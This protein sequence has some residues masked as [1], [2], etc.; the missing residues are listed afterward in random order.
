MDVKYRPCKTILEQAE[1]RGMATGLVATSTIT[2]ATPA[3]FSSHVQARGMEPEIAAQ[4]ISGGIDVLLGGG[5]ASFLPQNKGGNRN[6]KRNL[7]KEAASNGYAVVTSPLFLGSVAQTPLLGLFA[8]G[9]MAYEVDRDPQDEPS[10][11]DMTTTAIS[12]LSKDEDGFFLVVEGSRIDHAAHGH[13]P[14]AH[15]RDI[16][17]YDDALG[18]AIAFARE[19]PGTLVVS[20]ADHETGGMTLGR[21]GTYVYQPEMLLSAETSLGS[22]IDKVREGGDVSEIILKD[23]GISALNSEEADRISIAY[24]Q[25]GLDDFADALKALVNQ[26]AGIGWTS[27]GHTGVDVHL[28]AFGTGA[29]ALVGHH[30][31]DELGRLMAE[32]LGLELGL[33]T[34]SA[35]LPSALR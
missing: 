14:I 30:E 27:G 25:G 17:A 26:R 10:L 33:I 3:A 9:H 5:L 2:H 23:L 21:D 29:D 13:D 22:I 18:K 8:L 6:D 34:N 16:L 4:Q 1:K 15:I 19:N 20:T 24:T 12:L 11:A 32:L 28:G 35:D 7:L 31:N